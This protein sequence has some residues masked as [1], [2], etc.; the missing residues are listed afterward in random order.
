MYLVYE[1]NYG[2]N[3][4]D[5]V[6]P[7]GFALFHS[8]ESAL[9]DMQRRKGYLTGN[10]NFIF[11]EDKSEECCLVIAGNLNRDGSRDEEIHICLAVVEESDLKGVRA[12]TLL[13]NVVEWILNDS[14]ELEE[15]KRKLK[16]MGFTKEEYNRLGFPEMV[17]AQAVGNREEGNLAPMSRFDICRMM[18][19]SMN[20]ASYELLMDMQNN[21]LS[22][23]LGGV[24]VYRYEYGYEI[25]M[26]PCDTEEAWKKWISSIDPR[27]HQMLRIAHEQKCNILRLDEDGPVM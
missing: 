16:E 10:K 4:V 23:K 15:A 17:E 19:I 8:K 2:L 11:I 21:G 13:H 5:C 7:S 6:E 9:L 12:T 3:D 18:T 1:K 24:T 26:K 14:C 20:H 25:H 27:L 22:N